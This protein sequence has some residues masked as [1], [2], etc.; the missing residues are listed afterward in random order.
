[1][2]NPYGIWEWCQRAG[3]GPQ[4]S[5]VPLVAG[6]H[7]ESPHR[8]GGRRG[9]RCFGACGAARGRGGTGGAAAGGRMVVVTALAVDRPR[10]HAPPCVAVLGTGRPQFRKHGGAR[11]HRATPQCERYTYVQYAAS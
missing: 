1:M 2:T 8:S 7:P 4:T 3:G 5:N 11:K 9:L 10:A 6:G